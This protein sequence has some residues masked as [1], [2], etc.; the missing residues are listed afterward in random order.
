MS[1]IVIVHLAGALPAMLMG[2]LILVMPK[3]TPRHKLAGRIWVALIAVTSISTIWISGIN[4]GGGY[5]II[6]L[7]SIWTLI[8]VSLG[9]YFIRRGNRRAHRGFMIGTYLGLLGAAG[10]TLAPGRIISEFL[11][12]T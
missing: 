10:G 11:F 5:S 7:L 6:H 9:I 2:L 4:D 12:G 1:F 3:G 8:S